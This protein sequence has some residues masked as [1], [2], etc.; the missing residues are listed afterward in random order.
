MSK[1]DENEQVTQRRAK[2]DALRQSGEAF[3][4][5]FRRSHDSGT[6]CAT[7]ADADGETLEDA[8]V[9]VSIAGRLMTRRVMGKASFGNI[10][11]ESGDILGP[12]SEIDECGNRTEPGK[13]Q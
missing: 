10:R 11:D 3:P 13:R 8:A 9:E 6:I 4:N 7:Y 2:L 5:D 1:T 12:K